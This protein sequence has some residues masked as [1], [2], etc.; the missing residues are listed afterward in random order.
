LMGMVF[1][2]AYAATKWVEAPYSGLLISLI[3]LDTWLL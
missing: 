2:F 3:S 1:F